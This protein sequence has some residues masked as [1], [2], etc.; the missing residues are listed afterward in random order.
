MNLNN[1]IASQFAKAMQSEEKDQTTTLYGTIT[2]SND[3]T[4]V[5]ID[6]SEILTPVE[7]VSEV[8]EGDRVTVNIE[9]H[10]VVVTG[11]LTSPSTSMVSVD[12][13]LKTITVDANQIDLHGYITANGGFSI[14]KKGN[15]T[16]VNGTFTGSIK[17][18]STVQI[19]TSSDGTRYAFTISKAGVVGIG[20]TSQDGVYPALRI[21]TTGGL[22]IGGLSMYTHTDG[23]TKGVAE[24]TSLGT[25]YSCSTT[26]R[27]TYAQISEGIINVSKTS[28][29]DNGKETAV[30]TT[31]SDHIHLSNTKAVRGKDTDGTSVNLCHLGG[32]DVS[33]YGYGSWSSMSDKTYNAGSEYLG[34]YKSVLRAKERVYLTCNGKAADDTSGGAILYYNNN[35]GNYVFRPVGT[36]GNISCGTKTYPWKDVSAY[37]INNM[38]SRIKKE[39]IEYFNDCDALNKN[40][41][42]QSMINT[43][44]CYNF[45]KNDCILATYN[46][47]GQSK[48]MINFIAD[49]LLVNADGTDNIVG[50][51]ILNE[52]ELEEGDGALTYNLTNY[53]SV[54]VG[55]LQRSII[56]IEQLEHEIF[57]LKNGGN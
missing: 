31:I 15:I 54:V 53:I 13:K 1:E 19:G 5:K 49:D 39:N 3:E 43:T 16:A 7:T 23:I 24:I 2:I 30:K 41:N 51:L 27:Y 37:T 22:I 21:G 25:I 12:E 56:K 34:G 32:D 46:Y 17:G 8:R 10:K 6:G 35:D 44:D 57:R 11:N 29:D 55:A 40:I 20:N 14:D 18:D 28:L 52:I 26:E 47:I 9:N 36:S 45:I 4:C 48:T 33:R 50:Q 38:S 42:K